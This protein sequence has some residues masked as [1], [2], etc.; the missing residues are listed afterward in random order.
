MSNLKEM[1]LNA[2]KGAV[3]VGIEE[4][5]P[6]ENVSIENEEEYNEPIVNEEVE[7]E[8]G[9][10]LNVDV[11]AV[12][13]I[14]NLY[15]LLKEFSSSQ[16]KTI[17]DFV[18]VDNHADTAQIIC[19]SLV[20]NES[21]ARILPTILKMK[22]LLGAERAFALMELNNDDL[23]N[24]SSKVSSLKGIDEIKT[25]IAQKVLFCKEL[26]KN[27]DLLTED[28]LDSIM[29]LGAYLQVCLQ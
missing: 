15:E 12:N 11:D 9:L 3:S 22:N 23:L 29:T 1:F 10:N 7:T 27:I 26:N 21:S 18:K 25:P 28:D 13:K 6:Q 19:S 5:I 24:L 8:Q 17:A 16:Q 20:L 14:I 2:Q 4:E